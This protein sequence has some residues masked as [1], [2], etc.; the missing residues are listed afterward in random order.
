[1]V[2]I[3]PHTLTC[4]GGDYP[5][6]QRHMC[7]LKAGAIGTAFCTFPAMQDAHQI[8]HHVGIANERIEHRIVMDIHLCQ[9]DVGIT[10]KCLARS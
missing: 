5:A 2:Q 10:S 4:T 8:D 9:A 3:A 6:R 1:M 7:R